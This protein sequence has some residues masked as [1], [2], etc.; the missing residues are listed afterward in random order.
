MKIYPSS[1]QIICAALCLAAI[2]A[3]SRAEVSFKAIQEPCSIRKICQELSRQFRVRVTADPSLDDLRV[4]WAYRDPPSLTTILARLAELTN[5]EVVESKSS[6]G[7]PNYKL[8]RKAGTVQREAALRNT[9]LRRQIEGALSA[10]D[11]YERGALDGRELRACPES[12][13]RGEG[14]AAFD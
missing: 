1:M 12:V 14:D 4:T 5:S 7:E 6:N 8:E 10:A 11:Q 2:P 3:P 9:A 13:N